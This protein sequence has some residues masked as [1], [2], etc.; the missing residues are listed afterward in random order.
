MVERN[1]V[2]VASRESGTREACVKAPF[3]GPR[4]LHESQWNKDGAFSPQERDWRCACAGLLPPRHLTIEE[5]VALEL[6]HLR[7]KRDDLEKLIGLAALQDRNET[8]FYRVLIENM[9]ELMP[10][11]YTPTVGLVL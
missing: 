11:V 5:Q 2:T 10:I 9:A 7:A 8:L 6:E 3:S 1:P 4:L